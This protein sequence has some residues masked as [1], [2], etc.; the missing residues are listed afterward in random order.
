MPHPGMQ[1]RVPHMDAVP[2]TPHWAPSDAGSCTT[3]G[4]SAM[5]HLGMQLHAPFNDAVQCATY[6]YGVMCHLGIQCHA[7][8]MDA[9]PFTL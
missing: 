2:C 3:Y 1:C 9:V 6:E 7:P 8:P 5:R 4:R